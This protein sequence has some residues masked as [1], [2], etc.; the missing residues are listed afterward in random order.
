VGAHVAGK[1]AG[2]GEAAGAELACV[3]GHGERSRAWRA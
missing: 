2:A 3:L 1:G